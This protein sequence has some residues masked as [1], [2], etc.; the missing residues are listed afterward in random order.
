MD[1]EQSTHMNSEDNLTYVAYSDGTSETFEY[2]V[3]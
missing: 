2:D 1:L 3:V